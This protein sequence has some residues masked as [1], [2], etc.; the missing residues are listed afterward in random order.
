M[1][2]LYVFCYYTTHL[3]IIYRLSNTPSVGNI[4]VGGLTEGSFPGYTNVGY[5]DAF[6]RKYDSSGNEVFTRQ[7]GTSKIDYI[8]GVIHV[9][10]Y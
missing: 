10:I 5:S 6:I 7:F 8:E 4:I 9:C 1:N 3:L 2:Q